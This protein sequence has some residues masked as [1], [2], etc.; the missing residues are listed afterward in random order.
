MSADGK[1]PPQSK[2]LEEAIAELSR[3]YDVTKK[4]LE[5]SRASY[6]ELSSIVESVK[7]EVTAAKVEKFK[8]ESALQQAQISVSILEKSKLALEAEECRIDGR[9]HE[10]EQLLKA[11]AACRDSADRDTISRVKNLA[12]DYRQYVR[13]C[14]KYVVGEQL[15]SLN[16]EDEA[17]QLEF[18]KL[19]VQISEVS[20]AT[21]SVTRL[22]GKGD[23]RVTILPNNCTGDADDTIGAVRMLRAQVEKEIPL[24]ELQNEIMEAE[25]SRINE[26][27]S[28]L[29]SEIKKLEDVWGK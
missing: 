19:T 25:L 27:K 13:S 12:E 10:L 9:I 28:I 8:L 1:S 23:I 7:A 15:E 4:M 21:C 26:E 14:D 20:G 17:L 5:D 11:E 6:N 29:E 16:A 18:E 2:T 3:K 22:E 24:A